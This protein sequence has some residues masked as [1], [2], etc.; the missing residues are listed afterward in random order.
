MN[1]ASGIDVDLRYRTRLLEAPDGRRHGIPVCHDD[2]AA[3]HFVT[4]L[5]PVVENFPQVAHRRRLQ[6]DAPCRDLPSHRGR[7]G[8]RRRLC[9]ILVSLHGN[10]PTAR[11]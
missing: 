4:S 2:L 1:V 5:M 3:N 11:Q 6:I 10:R 9:T 7:N 8:K